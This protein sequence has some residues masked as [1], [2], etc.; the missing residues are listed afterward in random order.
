MARIRQTSPEQWTDPEF[1]AMTPLAR[2]LALAIR[3]ECDDN[4]TFDLNPRKLKMRL[5]P[6]D[7]CDVEAL[8][9]E[10]VANCQIIKYEINGKSY[11]MVRNFTK[12][13]RPKKPTFWNPV[14]NKFPTGYELH[15]S[16]TGGAAPPVPHQFP[17]KAE[18]PPTASPL[19]PPV[20]V[21]VAVGVEV[22]VEGK[23]GASA[24]GAPAEPSDDESDDLTPIPALD[25]SPEGAA[26]R[27]WNAMAE[28]AGLAQ[29]Q[30]LTNTRRVKLRKRLEE[31]GG[32]EGWK[33]ALAKV[34][35]SQFLLGKGTKNGR[36]WRADFDFLLQ[37]KSFTKLMEG[38]YDGPNPPNPSAA[39]AADRRA[40][41]E[42]LGLDANLA[43]E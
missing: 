26:V 28:R 23:S 8:I 15:S 20:T 27:A 6:G 1:V 18:P 16:Y 32:L 36:D 40:I 41:V 31:C 29:V 42:G 3:N 34:D 13:Q 10:L 5:L 11:G 22:E 33:T 4:G 35:G 17:T 38:A 21:A 19:P 2:L 9:G 24:P 43:A 30:R 37:Q 25:K 14:P 12:F 7:N 39:E